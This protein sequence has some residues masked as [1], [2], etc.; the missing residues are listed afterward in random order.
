MISTV[1]GHQRH[2]S[3]WRPLPCE[4][5][6]PADEVQLNWPTELAVS[7][8]DG[9]LHFVDDN[10]V[11]KL[12]D[13]GRVSVVAGRPLHS[14]VEPQSLAFAPNGDL[15]VA[16]SDSQRINRVRRISTDG[17]L[18]TYAGADSKCNCL[19]AA[20]RCFDPSRHLAAT[21]K[22]SSVASLACTPDGVLYI[23]DQGNYRV[24]S[25]SSSIP[26]EKSDGVFEV[27]DPDAQEL[28][29]FNK[30]GQ[31]VLTKDVMTSNVLYRMT[32]TQA[33][34]DGKLSSVV[35][36]H[37]RKLTFMRDY[38]GHVNAL[39]TSNGLKYNLRM[40]KVGNLE[41][42]D[43]ESTEHREEFKYYST[44][45][46][47]KSKLDSSDR[48]YVYEYD[49]FG[50]LVNAVAPTGES[51]S[52]TFNLTSAGA[53]IGLLRDGALS[54]VLH[55]KDDSVVSTAEGGGGASKTVS[56]SADKSL[57]ADEPWSQTTELSTEPH[58]VIAARTSD[59]VMGDSFPMVAAQSTFLG[60][61][62]VGTA[63]WEYLLSTNSGGGGRGRGQ[64]LGIK[65]QLQV[66]GETLLTVH[67]DK[68]QRREL[69][70]SGAKEELLETRYDSESRPMAWEPKVA[71]FA[72]V[73]QN[74]DRFGRLQN[75]SRGDVTE[76]YEYDEA[77]R[78]S[79]IS[80]GG[81]AVL[82]Y[83]YGTDVRPSAVT[84][85]HP[86]GRFAMVYGSEEGSGKGLRKVQT[87]R[88]HLHSFLLRPA[89]GSLRFQYFAPWSEGNYE[90]QV[91]A[92][93]N[94]LRKRVPGASGESVSFRYDPAGR[95]RQAVCGD[96]ESE[97]G[98][99]PRSGALESAVTKKG[100]TFDMRVRLKYHSGLLK[101][102]RVRFAGGGRPDLSGA[103]FRYQYDGNGRPSAV[104]SAVGGQDRQHTLN[105]AYGSNTGRLE[106]V[107]SLKFSRTSPAVTK[108]EDVN[109][110]F[111][112]VVE[113]DGNA[114]IKRLS[115]GL[116]R[117]EMLTFEFGYDKLGRIASKKIRDH[118]GRLSDEV[119]TFSSDSHLLKVTTSGRRKFDYAYDVNG[120][121]VGTT[122]ESE[123][124]GGGGRVKLQYDA[125]DRV[126]KTDDAGRVAYDPAGCVSRVG[127]R[128]RF[129]H[130]A[131]GKLVEHLAVEQSGM[132]RTIFRY[133]H[134]GR[135]A[136]W[137]DNRG[138]VQQF[139]Y[140]DPTDAS[141][142]THA[143]NPRSGLTQRLLYDHLGHLVQ[144]ETADQQMILVATDQSGSPVLAFKSDGSV[145]KEASYSPFGRVLSDSSAGM[146]LPVGFQGFLTLMPGLELLYDWR[147]GGRFYHPRLA[148]YLNPDWERLLR[149]ISSPLELF[150]Y[151][152]RNNDPV[153]PVQELDY[154]TD[155][156][157]WADLFGYNMESILDASKRSL[158]MINRLDA[159]RHRVSNAAFTS[160][161]KLISG[162]E[163]T[164]NNAKKSLSELSFVRHQDR[165][166]RSIVLNERV[167]SLPSALGKGFLL[168]VVNGLSIVNVVE[169]VPGVI[170]N[171]FESVLN[172]SR[173]LDVSHHPSAFK[174]IY[175]FA[176]P[177]ASEMRA[178]AD[179][180]D[181]LSGEYEVSGRDLDKGGRDLRVK[182]E[183][184]TLHVLYGGAGRQR[185]AVL[186]EQA[187]EATALA[188]AREKSLVQAGFSG[189]G[190]WTKGQRAELVMGHRVRGFNVVEIYPRN[191][192]PWLV[193]DASTYFFVPESQGV[194]QGSHR[195][196]S[197][198]GR[199]RKGH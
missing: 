5:A 42:F 40:S 95:L 60:S 162:M 125:G 66:N 181:R 92:A 192:W 57:R 114:R 178:D 80:R 189:Q 157:S 14:L 124:G 7:P 158:E 56:V 167:A 79:K 174:S 98:Y 72:G 47:L 78:L 52:L 105:L 107:G 141:R 13:D 110:N 36:S 99:D 15:F 30:F 139:F 62:L 170:Q 63:R 96:S 116:Q 19:D 185:D 12:T 171:V 166:T 71:G 45:G 122:G 41:S 67:F 179:N 175:Y 172:G 76:D 93:G 101:D 75:W 104:M 196:R 143:H 195:R 65:K 198:H 44:T 11:L 21:A 121:L 131:R 127:E 135:L 128:D 89:V 161:L 102:Q 115:Y 184:L 147:S 193:R 26:P 16:E 8:L 39:Q 165:F 144:I 31:H 64:M 190:D 183:G 35:D 84:T 29:I 150:V 103:Q 153:N 97:F 94:V 133:D 17:R 88:G 112:K 27:P 159:V 32:Y 55:I 176:K 199:T 163:T 86:D 117:R 138:R 188:W 142:P 70:Y 23:A 74:Y 145:L 43:A 146:A 155:L 58:P 59:P 82:Q 87:P 194:L 187:R 149:P 106:S 54:R 9:A 85:G 108:M 48:A 129:W 130:D 61:N 69:L 73:A 123:E 148:Q 68:L 10:V 33:T 169:G 38:K 120:N 113:L 53:S 1:V 37:G 2:R 111:R 136:A 156:A 126:E 50:R 109:S 154:M 151:R 132:T 24:R 180:V 46:L 137:H 81:V 118:Q 197:R 168:S 177:S 173:Y 28:Y 20:C 134:L 140:A 182:N 164:L 100:H 49:T 119:F 18:S 186:S 25:V 152:F 191:R 83:A 6:T 4:G 3:T 51:L 77:G 34:S 22:F 160:D 90:V 91:N